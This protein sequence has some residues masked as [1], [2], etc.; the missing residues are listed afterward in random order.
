MTADNP[1]DVCYAPLDKWG[2]CAACAGVRD[3]DVE[4]L[5]HA[6]VYWVICS[7]HGAL[8]VGRDNMYCA[9][10]KT[11]KGN[12]TAVSHKWL[13]RCPSDHLMDDNEVACFK[14]SV[15]LPPHAYE[16][17]LAERMRK[18][19]EREQRAQI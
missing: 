4:R 17:E 8:E 7:A 10:V 5:K 11:R 6:T 19:A 18:W 15:E 2:R 16:A 14:E 13:Y 9:T 12:R 1:C 3:E